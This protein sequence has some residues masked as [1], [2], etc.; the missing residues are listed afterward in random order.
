VAQRGTTQLNKQIIG[1]TMLKLDWPALQTHLEAVHLGE[2]AQRT[3]LGLVR[4]GD[5]LITKHIDTAHM[6]ARDAFTEALAEYLRKSCGPKVERTVRRHISLLKNVER[7]YHGFLSMAARSRAA[8][9]PAPKRVAAMLCRCA[10]EYQDIIRRARESNATQVEQ[11]LMANAQHQGTYEFNGKATRDSLLTAIA[12]TVLMEA[13]VHGWFDVE[14]RVV[15]PTLPLSD[16]TDDDRY[17]VG[18]TMLLAAHW[19]KWMETERRARYGGGELVFHSDPSILRWAPATCVEVIDF[20]PN[21]DSEMVDLVANLRL[22]ATTELTFDQLKAATRFAVGAKG[23]EDE[24]PL[25]PAG[26]VSVEEGHASEALCSALSY[27]L[28]EDQE[29]IKGVRLVEWLRGYAAL[30]A[31]ARSRVSDSV[32]SSQIF[33]VS[34]SELIGLL[35]RLGLVEDAARRFLAAITFSRSSRDL[36]DNPLLRQTD[37][38]YLIFAPALTQVNIAKAM[39]SAIAMHGAKLK[40]KGIGF[41]RRVRDLLTK[42]GHQVRQFRAKRGND[43]YEVDAMFVWGD[44]AFLLECKNRTLSG[45][46]PV[47]RFYF[48]RETREH[49]AQVKRLVKGLAQHPDILKEHCPEAL[50][51]TLVACVINGTPFSLPGGMDGVY[52]TDY[53]ELQRFFEAPY[54]ATITWPPAPSA[55]GVEQPEVVTSLWK[56][57][58]GPSPEDLIELMRMSPQ[59]LVVAGHMSPMVSWILYE[60]DSVVR[61]HDLIQT[62][63]TFESA[64]DVI[65]KYKRE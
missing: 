7:V 14:G 42:H 59:F 3:L 51:K 28:T 25:L 64:R 21:L 46:H 16:V 11:L 65:Q 23:I 27:D 1:D 6:A 62:D 15:L 63:V 20:K 2:E 43:E 26:S 8:Q 47:R 33:V 35:H 36:Y 58:A 52:M 29:R 48:E 45:N 5:S 50:G 10:V 44:W 4:R 31:Y 38:S 13:H 54:L 61:V 53:S 32:A 30:Q 19:W 55:D 49:A 17:C 57:E 34:S 9:M 18:T 60:D 22:F 12:G 24:V 41:E 56:S 40:P 39:L 37:G